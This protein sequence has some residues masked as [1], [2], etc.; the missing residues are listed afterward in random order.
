MET[1]CREERVFAAFQENCLATK[2]CSS[3]VLWSGV[4]ATPKG[5]LT[6]APKP[7][8]SVAPWAR[9]PL[10]PPPASQ[11]ATRHRPRRNSPRLCRPSAPAPSRWRRHSGCA[12]LAASRRSCVPA[13]RTRFS[14]PG[15]SGMI[16][17]IESNPSSLLD[18]KAITFVPCYLSKIQRLPLRV[19]PL[20]I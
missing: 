19:N 8:S 18:K 1:I 7:S 13:C 3:M 9:P 6:V 10:I 11:T 14:H 2:P 17:T 15:W 5:C 16:A 12:H 20:L 4:C